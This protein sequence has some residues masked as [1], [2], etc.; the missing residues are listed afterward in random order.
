MT[1]HKTTLEKYICIIYFVPERNIDGIR[2]V[3][4]KL[5]CNTRYFMA[6]E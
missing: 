6:R 2:R 5:L 4:N 3:N 1:V